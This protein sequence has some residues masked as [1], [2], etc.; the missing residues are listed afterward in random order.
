M[1]VSISAVGCVNAGSISKAIPIAVSPRNAIAPSFSATAL[2]MKR[3][4][5]YALKHVGDV[6]VLKHLANLK[7]ADPHP[8]RSD[9]IDIILGAD[10]YSSII[11]D[12][13]WKGGPGEPFAQN[14]IFGWII[15]GPVTSSP[16]CSDRAPTS[17]PAASLS[18]IVSVHHGSI[19]ASIHEDIKRF[20]EIEE[21]PHQTM[22]TD[23]EK[24]CEDHFSR[25]SF[26]IG[27]RTVHSTSSV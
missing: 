25:F 11:L 17:S 12:G 9:A 13:I 3:F 19:D 14:S 6:R 18:S 24:R 7:W 4:T 15:S 1:P 21:I 26:A 5:S 16:S 10:L 2:I 20:W 23:D 22:F 27:E 8:G